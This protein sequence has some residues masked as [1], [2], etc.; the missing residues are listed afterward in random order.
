MSVG[1]AVPL[2]II[3]HNI[4]SLFSSLHAHGTVVISQLRHDTFFV[5]WALF[6]I[7]KLSLSLPSD[8]CSEEELKH[9]VTSRAPVCGL[10]AVQFWRRGFRGRTRQ[11]SATR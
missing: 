10:R 2:V 3:A 5:P 4:S 8:H 9:A 6:A 7:N 1:V 11:G